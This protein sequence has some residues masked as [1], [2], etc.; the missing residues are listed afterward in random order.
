M[1]GSIKII[2]KKNLN[3]KIIILIIF[4]YII[5]RFFLKNSFPDN[6]FI[7]GYLN[8]LMVMP[9]IFRIFYFSSKILNIKS[10]PDDKLIYYFVTFLLCSF[11]FEFL[12]PI[13]IKNST[14]DYLDIFFYGLGTSLDYLLKNKFKF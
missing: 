12:R 4:I 6:I 7:I 9:L 11:C 8:D 3:I 10:F 1:H 13:F 5:N 14:F 2:F